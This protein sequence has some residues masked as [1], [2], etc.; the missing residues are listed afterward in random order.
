MKL[1]NTCILLRLIWKLLMHMKVFVL[2]FLVVICV[3]YWFLVS[4]VEE[5]VKTNSFLGEFYYIFNVAENGRLTEL[6]LKQMGYERRGDSYLKPFGRPFVIKVYD[7]GIEVSLS[8]DGTLENVD[9]SIS[10]RFIRLSTEQ[11]NL[12]RSTALSTNSQEQSTSNTDTQ[13]R[14]DLN[15]DHKTDVQ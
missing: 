9:D 8:A 10:P 6:E 13:E 5:R 1:K 7:S 12:L 3:V 2:I 14:S 15:A 4:R 11:V